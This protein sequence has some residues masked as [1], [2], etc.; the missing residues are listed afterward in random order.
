[1]AKAAGIILNWQDFSDISDI[2]PL[3][4]RIYP[5]GNADVNHFH[6]AGGL[7]FVIGELLEA[8]LLHRDVKTVAGG[9]LAAY[10]TEP[11]L[12]DHG[13]VIWKPLLISD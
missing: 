9:G 6:A 12:D 8:G 3:L 5:N 7:G 2:T 11:R 1:M 4:G 13:A 10:T